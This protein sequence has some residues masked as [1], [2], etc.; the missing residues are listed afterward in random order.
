MLKAVVKQKDLSDDMTVLT[1]EHVSSGNPQLTATQAGSARFAGLC[2]VTL[3]QTF[4]A[5]FCGAHFSQ[6][7]I[8]L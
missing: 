7:F 8:S 2:G 4:C 3:K 6:Q 5:L 1:S